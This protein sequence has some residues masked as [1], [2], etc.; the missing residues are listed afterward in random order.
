[1]SIQ[2]LVITIKVGQ[3]EGRE[4]TLKNG[5]KK[6]IAD[7]IGFVEM[8]DE[9]RKVRIP[10]DVEGGQVPYPAGRYALGASSF[11]VGK[12]HDLEINR[13]E[14]AL[15]PLTAAVSKAG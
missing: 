15:V 10:I 2:Q 11:S 3:A 7:Q 1:M 14:M 8:N 13:Y 4:I 9:V 6:K 12:F 5:N